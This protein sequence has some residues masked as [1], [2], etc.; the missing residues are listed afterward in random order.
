MRRSVGTPDRPP[1]A[2]EVGMLEAV[3]TEFRPM[4]KPHAV[5]LDRRAGQKGG[6]A[7]G[8]AR[9]K[10]LSARRRVEI[11]RAAARARWGALPER[12]RPLFPGYDLE[13][14][15]LPDHIDLVMLHV[16]TRGGEEDRRWLVGR[17][18]DATIRRWILR[19]RGRGLMLR[20]MTPWVT[21]RTA[22]RWQAHDEYAL[23]WE[24]R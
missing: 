3:Y 17:F 20:H 6:P 18:G 19:R 16:L 22:R 15:K 11:A 4:K 13:H 12:L 1:L 23:L 21:E 8:R 2:L 5:A 10:A 14:I 7:A 24:N 9:A